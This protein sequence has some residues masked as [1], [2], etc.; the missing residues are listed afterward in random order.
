MHEEARRFNIQLFAH[1]FTD[2]DQGLATLA[3]STRLWFM[4]VFNARQVIRQRLTTGSRT[5]LAWR[6]RFGCY[7]SR[8]FG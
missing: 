4:T 2:L 7:P 6:Q 3:A 8:A 5:G 1:V